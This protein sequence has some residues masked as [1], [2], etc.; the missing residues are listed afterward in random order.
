MKFNMLAALIEALNSNP[1]KAKK[2]QIIETIIKAMD[3]S[4]EDVIRWLQ[5]KNEAGLINSPL[6]LI[7]RFEDEG[8][9]VINGFDENNKNKLWGIYLKGIYVSL[10]PIFDAS[11]ETFKIANSIVAY[12][13]QN[14]KH[15]KLPSTKIIKDI[16]SKELIRQYNKTLIF[17]EDNG[18]KVKGIK[19]FLWCSDKVDG[20]DSSG[21]VI[22][23]QEGSKHVLSKNSLACIRVALIFED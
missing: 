8:L 7:Y 5:N 20:D 13:H 1:P 10:N 11:R 3:L 17:L 22:D 14:D 19:E 2:L 15:G 6:P 18:V 4:L 23:L 21:I 12:N 9:R 16:W